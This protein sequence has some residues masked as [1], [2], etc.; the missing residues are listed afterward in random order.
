MEHPDTSEEEE[1]N[2]LMSVSVDKHYLTLVSAIYSYSH[3]CSCTSD[4]IQPEEGQLSAPG[5]CQPPHMNGSTTAPN[6]TR[7]SRFCCAAAFLQNL[8]EL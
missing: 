5:T 4:I 8:N 7:K 3:V 6:S 2:E 1:T